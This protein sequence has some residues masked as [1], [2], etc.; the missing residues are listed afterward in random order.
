[1][2]DKRRMH[3][4]FVQSLDFIAKCTCRTDHFNIDASSRMKA[5]CSAVQ[6]A[7][8]SKVERRMNVNAAM[9]KFMEDVDLS[10]LS[11]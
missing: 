11:V 7:R 10:R 5:R 1:M 9:S 4:Q 8:E 2:K 3:A 6:P